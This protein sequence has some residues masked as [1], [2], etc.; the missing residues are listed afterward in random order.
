MLLFRIIALV[1]FFIVMTTAAW[2]M[3]ANGQ[4]G[5]GFAWGIAAGCIVGV[6]A[7]SIERNEKRAKAMWPGGTYSGPLP[8]E[9]PQ[10]GPR[11]RDRYPS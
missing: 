11:E 9:Q 2:L 4:W 1:I 10:E 7:G 3:K 5:A 6:W 8:P